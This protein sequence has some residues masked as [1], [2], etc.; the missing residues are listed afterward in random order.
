MRRRH[1]LWIIGVGLALG[2]R[3][4][5]A[6]QPAPQE[7]VV[8]AAASLREVFEKVAAD[9]E[10]QHQ[11]VTVRLSFA[12]SQELRTQLEHG[13]RADVFASADPKHLN[14]LH[15]LGLVPAPVVFARNRPV[16]VVPAANPAKLAT[17]ADLPK[18]RYIVLGAPEVPIGAYAD[19]ILIAAGKTLGAAFREQV[20]AHVRSRELNVRQVLTKVTLG[21]AEAGIVYQTDAMTAKDR[22]LTLVIPETVNVIADY[23]VAPLAAAPQPELARAFVAA[24]LAKSGQAALAAAGFMPVASPAVAKDKK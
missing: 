1:L 22:V 4:G 23:A 17:F 21:E 14:L 20:L 2:T 13:A 19:A 9:F 5:Q 12:G 7:V 3:P 8:F 24:L 16:V 15:G 6:A 11:G 10:K 18:A